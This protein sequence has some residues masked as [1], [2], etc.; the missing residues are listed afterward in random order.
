M[1][2]MIT[3]GGGGGGWDGGSRLSIVFTGMTDD[4]PDLSI[5]EL[6][7]RLPDINVE[8][9]RSGTYS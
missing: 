5:D 9:G 7:G 3:G 2:L 6:R 4:R 1:Y 8:A